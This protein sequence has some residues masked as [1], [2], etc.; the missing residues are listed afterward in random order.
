MKDLDPG[1][2]SRVEKNSDTRIVINISDHIPESCFGL[3]ILK[4]LI[5]SVLKIWDVKT[6][7]G[8]NPIPG[9]RSWIRN[10]LAF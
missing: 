6:R 7:S 5:N 9:E 4:F 3:K 2:V 8:K 1:Y 10:T